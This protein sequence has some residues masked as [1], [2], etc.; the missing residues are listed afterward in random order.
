MIIRFIFIGVLLL[1]TG[2]ALA[3]ERQQ[4]IILTSFPDTIYQPFKRA[5]ENKNP[6]IELFILNRKTSAAI[7][8]IQDG[9]N[10]PVDL[11]WASAPDAFEILKQSGKL[12]KL[13]HLKRSSA[14]KVLGYP[15]NDP[16]GYDVEILQVPST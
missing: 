6:D 15:I 7:S 12:Q 16:D 9:V 2:M 1:M 4:L 3:Q 14:A 10:Y 8:Y 11:F 13:Q 5:F